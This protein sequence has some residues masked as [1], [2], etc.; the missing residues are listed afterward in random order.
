MGTYFLKTEQ[1][2]DKIDSKGDWLEI[3]LDRGE[4]S[5]KFFSEN[6]A[7]RGVRFFGVDADH[8]QVD[9]AHTGL[10]ITGQAVLQADGSM[11]MQTSK[12]A[13]H[14]TLVHAK[15]ED[16][17]LDIAKKD[18]NQRFSLAYLDNFDWDYWLGG[19]EEKWVERYKQ[20]YRDYMKIEM[21]N[22]H[23]SMTHLIQAIRLLPMMTEK[24]IIVCDDTWY[25]PQEGIFIGKC[26]AAIPYLL[27]NGYS[28][29]NN[30]GYRQNSGAILGRGF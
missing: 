9:R 19:P 13:D 8:N 27:V 20:H 25:H 22:M 30:E 24:S 12:L 4:G 3:G 15:G 23:S 14:I 16:F 5:T 17:L 26:A 2:M 18:P 1:F 11:Q 10:S 7:K 6:A 21:T 28:I 29:V